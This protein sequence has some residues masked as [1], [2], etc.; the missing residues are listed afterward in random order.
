MRRI[1]KHLG[2]ANVAATAALVFAMAG[3]AY[4]ALTPIRS[5]VIHTCFSRSTG[6]LRVVNATARC[7]RRERPLNFNQR[8]PIGAIGRTGP[9]GKAGP[10]GRTGATGKTGAN[11]TSVT[12]SALAAGSGACPNGGSSFKSASGTTYVCSGTNGSALAYASVNLSGTLASSKDVTNDAATATGVYCFKLSVTPSVGVASV[13]GDASA[14]GSAEVLIPA[15]AACSGSGDTSAE[16]LTYS[17]TGAPT[18]LPFD[19]IFN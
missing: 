16:V 10:T 5:G 9:A 17:A 11:G 3:G 4:A 2:Y 18:N 19:V 15:G 1:R 7:S 6:A 8:G 14:A 12:S 13:R